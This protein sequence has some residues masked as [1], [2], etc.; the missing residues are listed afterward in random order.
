MPAFLGRGG[1]GDSWCRCGSCDGGELDGWLWRRRLLET[2]TTDT[3]CAHG[4]SSSSWSIGG[5]ACECHVMDSD[6]V[7]KIVVHEIVPR[8]VARRPF[9]KIQGDN[10]HSMVVV[11]LVICGVVDIVVV[12]GDPGGR[13]HGVC[14]GPMLAFCLGM[15]SWSIRKRSRMVGRLLPRQP[16]TKRSY[17]INRE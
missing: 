7:D 9:S 15:W 13:V 4:S 3:W 8:S 2:R 10:G 11:V 1:K 12:L 16:Q 5:D 17:T 14:L 6:I